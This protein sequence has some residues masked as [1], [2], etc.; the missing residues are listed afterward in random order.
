MS[1]PFA[2]TKITNR[3]RK[4]AN[5]ARLPA[6]AFEKRWVSCHAGLAS[7]RIALK[8]TRRS[9]MK[10]IVIG[11]FALV[12]AVF[13]EGVAEAQFGGP[14]WTQPAPLFWA[15][16]A[17]VFVPAPP[18]TV[19]QRPVVTTTVVPGSVFG[20]TVVAQPVVVSPPPMRV[21]QPTRTVVTRRGPFGRSVSRVQYG[22]RPF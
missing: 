7:G 17:P 6:E 13:C 1:P 12:A 8:E 11:C 3:L 14:V 22:F 18:V 4:R 5:V 9:V 2:A 19:V 10:R 20:P 15:Q 21:Y 16:P